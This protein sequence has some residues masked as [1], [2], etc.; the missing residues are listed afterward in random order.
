MLWG[1]QIFQDKKVSFGFD[2]DPIV[3]NDNPSFRVILDPAQIVTTPCE[4]PTSIIEI[5]P[6]ACTS[7]Y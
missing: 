1:T 5:I 4:N 6:I 2:L 3:A 7:V